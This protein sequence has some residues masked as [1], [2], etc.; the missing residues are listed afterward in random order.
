MRDLEV[1]I[2]D[3]LA[4]RSALPT[5]VPLQEAG[6]REVTL[7]QQKAIIDRVK[8]TVYNAEK[9]LLEP[10]PGRWIHA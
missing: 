5:H 8:M 6:P 2:A 9:W 4:Q 3:L 1:V 10:L 7:L